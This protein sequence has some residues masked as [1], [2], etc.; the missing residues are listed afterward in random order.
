M[1]N[2]DWYLNQLGITQYVLRKPA[3]IKG[4]ASISIAENIRLIVISQSPPHDK[5]FYDILKA[6][7]LS[8]E[9]C[10]ILSPTQ[11]I[12]PLEQLNQVIWLIDTAVPDNWRTSPSLSQKA[13]I[14]TVD[15][16]QLTSSATL[17]RQLWNTLCQYENYFRAN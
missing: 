12:M 6:I 2:S 11:L 15:L 10:L 13:L 8:S 1:N 9:D 3:A 4:E 17:K 7:G 5:I 16:G 14:E